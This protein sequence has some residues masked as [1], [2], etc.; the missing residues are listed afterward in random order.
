MRTFKLGDSIQE[1]CEKCD[2]IETATM[3]YRNVP[4]SNDKGIVK[5][6]LAG[7]CNGCHGVILLPQQSAPAINKQLSSQLQQSAVEHRNKNIYEK[8]DSASVSNPATAGAFFGL[9]VVLPL[10]T[11][12][13]LPVAILSSACIIAVIF[14][15]LTKFK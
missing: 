11:F 8:I 15:E 5:N 14:K 6:I 9:A 7:V 4:L 1:L 3:K 12:N 2:R 13:S 10:I